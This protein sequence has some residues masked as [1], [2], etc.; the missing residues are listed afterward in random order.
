VIH[1]T[2]GGSTAERTL[3]CPAWVG[4]SKNIP[5]RPAGSAALEGSMHHYVQE[6]CRLH[7]KT[8]DAFLGHVY[9]EGDA[10]RTFMD[11]D[12][13]LAWE[14]FN[15]T[16]TLL[17]ELEIDEFLIEPFVQ[18]VE[19][20]RGGSIDL[21]GV[22]EDHKTVVYV[23]YKFGRIGVD[24]AKAQM[25]FY[26]V[27]AIKDPKFTDM[28]SQAERIICAIV[29]PRAGGVKLHEMTAPE[30]EGFED[31]MAAAI[32]QAQR[33]DAPARAGD[34][35]LFCPAAPYCAE[36]RQRANEAVLIDPVNHNSLNVAAGM[37]EDVEAWLKT[38]KEEMHN[39]LSRGVSVDGWKLVEKRHQRKWIDE[40]AVRAAAQSVGLLGEI[41][42]TGLKSVAQAEKSLKGKDLDLSTFIEAVSGGTT[43]ARADDKRPPVV[44]TDI[45]GHLDT[46]MNQ[47][48][49]Q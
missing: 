26:A 28:V 47:K 1:L 43:I 7:G 24:P 17:D 8:P 38:V 48:Q 14:A 39:Q 11:D 31:R 2:F 42:T 3:Q 19:G 36:R 21:I 33:P 34:H 25:L 35:C 23:D 32:T 30:L 44:V 18:W 15:L 46:L 12:L 5:R 49:D 20:E 29:Q 37:V 40:S 4:R 22:T 27:C 16:D 41:T 6:Q 9:K 10:A 45:V 13:D